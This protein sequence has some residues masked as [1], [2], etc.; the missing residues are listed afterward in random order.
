LSAHRFQARVAGV[1]LGAAVAAIGACGA[2]EPPSGGGSGSG[3]DGEGGASSGGRGGASG[4]GGAGPAA[5]GAAGGGL[6]GASGSG[7][8]SAGGRGGAGSA[9]SGGSGA[10]TD[11]A[12]GAPGADASVPGT[13][14]AGATCTWPAGYTGPPLGQCAPGCPPGGDCGVVKAQG[15][16]LT[17]DDFEAPAVPGTSI[18][19]TWRSRDGRKGS[20]HL[21]SDPTAAAQMALGPAGTGGSPASKQ[22]VHVWGGPGPWGALMSLSLSC[23]DASAY[24]GISFWIKGN[25]AAGNTQIKLDVVTPATLPVA[26]GGVCTSRC[27]NHF[28]KVVDLTG[29][30][31]RHKIPWSA[32]QLTNCAQPVPA[33]PAAFDPQKMILALA[34]QQPD[35]KAGFDFWIDDVTF[36]VDTRPATNFGQI[37]T[38]AVFKEIFSY[39]APLPVYTHPG[40]VAAVAAQ[41]KGQ[42]AQT[43]SDLDRKHEAAAFLAQIGKETG[44]LTRVRESACYPMM[45]ASCTTYGT[46][47]QN[48]YGRGAIQLTYRANYAEAGAAFPGIVAN[49]DTVATSTAIAY[50]TAVWFWMSKGCHGQIM[51]QNFGGTTRLING[52]LECGPN[53]R[54]KE[55]AQS[56]ADNYREICAALGINA[57]GNLLC[58]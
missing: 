13:G 10:G 44:S 24:D 54:S 19:I 37:I 21:S 23:Y 38:E 1:L 33:L 11:A 55:G 31:T 25:P 51:A 52:A 48:Y 22:A 32:L 4:R 12:A 8:V 20:W 49:P 17:L 28:G 14:G 5:G 27:N 42:L 16:F 36:D 9:G 34:F 56:R 40:L 18:P 26:S 29:T 53:P 35:A 6:G 15:G 57:R 47:D 30:W 2:A 45:T 58:P 39:Q 41:G 43:G 3:G 46:A 50:G 7:G